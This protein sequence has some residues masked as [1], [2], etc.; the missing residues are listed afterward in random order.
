MNNHRYKLEP[1]KG[2][3]T[4]YHCPSCQH[5]TKTFTRYIDTHT[6][7]HVHPTVGKCER[8]NNCGYHYTPKKYFED[9]NINT[10]DK[11]DRP[12][13]Q[14]PPPQPI[15]PVSYIDP[16]IFKASLKGYDNNHFITY[17]ISLFGPDI[18]TG[19]I[20]KY[21]IGTSKHWEGATVFWQ[22]DLSN[23]IRSGKVML[24]NPATGK[25]VKKPFNHIT[26]VHTLLKQTEFNLSQCFFG[27]HLIKDK[28]KPIALVESEKTAI[29]ASVYLPQYIWLSV[30][31]LTNLTLD[32]CRPL[33]GRTIVLFP[34]IK[35]MEAWSAKAEELRLLI[36]VSVSDLLENIATDQ[37]R[38]EGL[39]IADYLIRFD[40]KQ[41]R[42]PDNDTQLEP[43]K[44]P[45]PPTPPKTQS[46]QLQA[47][48]H[49]NP[50]L[51]LLV[52]KFGLV[53]DQEPTTNDIW[54]NDISATVK[55]IKAEIKPERPY[56][57]E[58][59]NKLIQ[60]YH[61]ALKINYIAITERLIKDKIIEINPF[62]G[63]AYYQYGSTPF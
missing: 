58:D 63:N 17:L 34:D 1:Y 8:L 13:R 49:K 2:M 14:P 19:L 20:E 15:K 50:S 37:E 7:E 31:S 53:P 24:Y 6:D 3:N 62:Y 60:T 4:R 55:A 52:E 40:W 30:G 11:A 12:H 23:K 10:E 33:A 26:W 29:I 41:F 32:K 56:T 27:L 44:E 5:R 35:G 54:M 18:T 38:E 16:A 28:S 25:R 57:T 22:T 43:A 59:I 48:I 61:N 21:F 9:N 47:M 36:N 46:D 39:D 42:Q 51:G 45:E